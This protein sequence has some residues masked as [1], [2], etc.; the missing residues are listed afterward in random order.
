MPTSGSVESVCALTEK[1]SGSGGSAGLR[2]EGCRCRPLCDETAPVL[3]L[4]LGNPLMSDDG[5]GQEL[6]AKL[7]SEAARWGSRVEFMDGGTQ[8]LALLG[9][10]EG[11]KA[12]VFLDA[13]RLGD[14]AGAVHVLKGNELVRLGGARMATAHEGSAPQIL[15]ALQLLGEVPADV[16]MVG[17]EPEQIRTGIGLSAPVKAGLGVAEGLARTTIENILA[18]LE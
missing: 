15:A 3:L 14:Q 8:G 16:V 13:V 12:V 7:Q 5:A 9:K 18:T 6:L 1:H 11:R 2:E 4:A 17:I 10:F